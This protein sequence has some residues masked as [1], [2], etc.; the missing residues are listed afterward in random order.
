MK[1]R[2]RKTPVAARKPKPNN[3][4]HPGSGNVFADIGLS[5]AQSRLAKA[6]LAHQIG[7]LIGAAGLS[8]REAAERLGIDQPKVSA[9]LLGRLKDFSTERLMKF[10]TAL[11]R[12]VVI[13]VR[14]PEDHEHPAL[15][16]LVEA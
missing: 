16:V 1:N 2:V 6:E 7:L 13:T 4:V 15:R 11:D 3:V 9:L 14:E 5:D 12:D 8:Q 10:I